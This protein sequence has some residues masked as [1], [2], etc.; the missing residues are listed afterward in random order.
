MHD[1]GI[2][3]RHGAEIWQSFVAKAKFKVWYFH[4]LLICKWRHRLCK[5]N[6]VGLTDV[7]ISCTPTVFLQ[8]CD[9][10]N[11]IFVMLRNISC[12]LLAGTFDKTEV[13]PCRYMPFQVTFATRTEGF[14]GHFAHNSLIYDHTNLIVV[15][16]YIE[17]IRFWQELIHMSWSMV[18]TYPEKSALLATSLVNFASQ[19][20]L[21]ERCCRVI[22]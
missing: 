7:T 10:T 2:Q 15:P 13:H 20:S 22:S 18:M 17:S 9:G 11:G 4:N 6:W 19:T 16:S 12:F 14:A 5:S 8:Q 1:Q 3:L 21:N